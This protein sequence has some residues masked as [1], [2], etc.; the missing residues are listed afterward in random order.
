[1]RLLLLLLL[2]APAA[3]VE[4]S[5]LVGV[6]VLGGQYFFGRQKGALSGN[7]SVVAAPAL[8]FDDRWALLPSVR[9]SYQG[10]KSV[11]DLVG[12]GTLF[13]EQM[14]HRLGARAVYQ[15]DG[16]RWRLK[17]SAS[18]KYQLLRETKD[19]SWGS[20]LFDYRKWSIGG[21][22]EFLYLDPFGV[23]AAVDYFE[24]SFPNYASLES[25]AAA[26]LSG[27]ARELAGDRV[28]DS[29]NVGLAVSGELP[30]RERLILEGGLSV[31]YS[32]FPEQK[33]VDDSGQLTG[34]SRQ[35]ALT[36][37]SLGARM[38]GELNPDLRLLGSL[39]LSFS[40]LASDQNDY[41]ARDARY[42]ALYYNHGELRV[43]P[44][45]KL[46]IGPARQPVVLGL[47]GSWT[48]R[49]YPHRPAQTADGIYGGE[50]LV[51]DTWLAAASLTYPMAKR[52]SLVFDWQLG[53]ARSNQR[54]EQFYSYNY[55]VANYL[56]GFRYDY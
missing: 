35:D 52:F 39:D 32:R 14:D 49:R 30:A 25:R 10:T 42:L 7:A 51:T 20:G 55:S 19:E 22:A 9:S 37:L 48:R 5:P 53:R 45:V 33:L 15:P 1:M 23:R 41:D 29:K 43:A 11:V 47:S 12:A 40:Y 3:A 36:S 2:A 21:E 17:P 31:V 38:P 26:S 8:R 6:Q 18:F 54:F 46:L 44:G 24:T 27:M 28:L 56:F 16:S 34:R 50:P 4:V 13:Q